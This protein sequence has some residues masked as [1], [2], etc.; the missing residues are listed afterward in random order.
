MV[1]SRVQ[2]G[3]RVAAGTNEDTVSIL[4]RG[5][6]GVAIQPAL[7]R[8]GRR[9]RGGTRRARAWWRGGW[10]NV[11]TVRPAALLARAWVPPGRPSFHALFERP[12]EEMPP[13]V[14][15]PVRDQQKACETS[16]QRR[17]RN[18]R[19]PRQCLTVSLIATPASANRGSRQ[20]VTSLLHA[21]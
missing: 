20:L 5:S 2:R 1:R 7:S 6:I 8:L 10:T 14:R 18:H 19:P 16:P 17:L 9:D 21:A 15:E 12:P 3:L 11:A 4:S 13:L